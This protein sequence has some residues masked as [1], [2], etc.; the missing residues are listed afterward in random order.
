MDAPRNAAAPMKTQAT[1]LDPGQISDHTSPVSPPRAAP[2]AIP[3]FR[4]PPQAPTL[5]VISVVTAL[6]SSSTV[7]S[8]RACGPTSATWFVTVCVTG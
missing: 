8:P 7:I 1:K 3:G 2:N 6:A 5:T 4:V